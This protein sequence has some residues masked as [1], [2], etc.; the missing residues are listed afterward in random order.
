[1]ILP[2]ICKNVSFHPAAF[3]CPSA[4]KID[5]SIRLGLH[6][7]WRE[8]ENRVAEKNDETDISCSIPAVIPR[9]SKT[10]RNGKINRERNLVLL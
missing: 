10:K 4:E 2:P 6:L 1:L 9:M 3:S 8:Q 5:C 7:L